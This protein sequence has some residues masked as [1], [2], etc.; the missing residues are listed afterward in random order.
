[1]LSQGGRERRVDVQGSEIQ[2]HGGLNLKVER[3]LFSLHGW[4][5]FPL[6]AHGNLAGYG[7][8]LALGAQDRFQFG[9]SSEPCRAVVLLLLSST[10]PHFARPFYLFPHSDPIPL[11][12]HPSP[13]SPPLSYHRQS[14]IFD[15]M[16]V[17]RRPGNTAGKHLQQ[18]YG[19]A[20][21]AK[22]TPRICSFVA[23]RSGFLLPVLFRQ[24]LFELHDTKSEMQRWI[25]SVWS[26]LPHGASRGSR[27]VCGGM[28][29]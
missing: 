27:P 7:L 20:A 28:S 2:S 25:A 19:P 14:T 13:F 26:V 3:H 16:G 8:P 6:G 22:G 11:P 10:T 5:S 15:G 17:T 12:L 1:M 29:L 18:H 4:P 21:L 9:G 24:S 23:R